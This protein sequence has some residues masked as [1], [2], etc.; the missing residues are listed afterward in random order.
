MPHLYRCCCTKSKMTGTWFCMN[1]RWY[2]NNPLYTSCQ[3]EQLMKIH[4]TVQTLWFTWF[5]S[6]YTVRGSISHAFGRQRINWDIT[7]RT[8]NID[9]KVVDHQALLVKIF[10][11]FY[12]IF[13]CNTGSVMNRKKLW[14]TSKSSLKYLIT[15]DI[16]WKNH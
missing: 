13:G 12:S 1:F 9:L 4:T 7:V 15:M 16:R 14:T 11:S 3:S 5:T 8:G 6:R 10:I 2:P